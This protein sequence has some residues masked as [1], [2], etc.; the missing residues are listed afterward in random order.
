MYTKKKERQSEGAEIRVFTDS[1]NARGVQV[2]N[3]E[4]IDKRTTAWQ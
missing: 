3:S 2:T 4:N 1:G